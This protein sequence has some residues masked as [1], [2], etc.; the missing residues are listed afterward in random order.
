MN[1]SPTTPPSG[2]CQQ[3]RTTTNRR[4][5]YSMEDGDQE[6]LVH[7]LSIGLRRS[8]NSANA[9]HNNETSPKISI[10][11][12]PFSPFSPQ[13]Q[14]YHDMRE[15]SSGTLAE[16]HRRANLSSI[17]DAALSISDEVNIERFRYQPHL[18]N[19][20]TSLGSVSSNESNE[21]ESRQ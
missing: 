7:A 16:Q 10:E 6:T 5:T 19:S 11:A 21:S 3:R 8:R 1:F 18:L 2:S 14:R 15:S 20:Q 12:S 9:D 17:L 13:Q 4:P